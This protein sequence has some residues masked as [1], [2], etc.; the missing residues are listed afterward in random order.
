[1]KRRA[2]RNHGTHGTGGRLEPRPKRSRGSRGNGERILLD[3]WGSVFGSG[4]LHLIVS[5]WQ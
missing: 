4:G 2:C 3:R 1:M 5:V